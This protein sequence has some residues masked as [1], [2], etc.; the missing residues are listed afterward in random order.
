[1]ENGI[2]KMSDIQCTMYCMSTEEKRNANHISD[3]KFE[4]LCYRIL[5]HTTSAPEHRADKC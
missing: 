2:L 1:M 5:I 3:V 4:A